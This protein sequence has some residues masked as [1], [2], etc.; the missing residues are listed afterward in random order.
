[1][2]IKTSH[3]QHHDHG[4]GRRHAHLV[5]RKGFFIDQQWQRLGR[6]D[7]PAACKKKDQN[8]IP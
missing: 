3:D 5:K 2:I 1:M 6:C 4:I 8:R 7:W